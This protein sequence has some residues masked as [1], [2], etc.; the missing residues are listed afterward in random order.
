MST[1]SD[2]SE[3]Y[4]MF[5]SKAPVDYYDSITNYVSVEEMVKYMF[6]V[7]EEYDRCLMKKKNA[8]TN[9]MSGRVMMRVSN[10][11]S[12][13]IPENIQKMAISKYLEMIGDKK[14]VK[15][16]GMEKFGNIEGVIEGMENMNAPAGDAKEEEEGEEEENEDVEGENNEYNENKNEDTEDENEQ[17]MEEFTVDMSK[18]KRLIPKTNTR[19][20]RVRTVI[21]V[22]LLLVALYSA[23]KICEDYNKINF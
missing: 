14:R 2:I 4:K 21:I 8:K 6:S 3:D 10:G 7:L 15:N 13:E 19:E 20:E 22:I 9:P 23:F 17:K 18:F 12:F 11:L 5:D 1:Y 16:S